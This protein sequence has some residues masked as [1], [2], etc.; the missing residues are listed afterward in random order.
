MNHDPSSQF[1]LAL[2]TGASSGI[3]QS[4]CRLLASN[5]ISL[6]VNGRNQARLEELA[7]DLRSHVPVIEC[8]ADLE[9][10]RGKEK[11]VQMIREY[12]PDLVV[13]S[14]GFGLY[15][16]AL[17]YE[18]SQQLAIVNLNVQV[19]LE[20]TLEAAQAMIAHKKSGVILNISSSTDRLIFPNFSV[21]SASKAFVTH[22]SRSLDYEMRSQ[23]VAVLAACPGMV[24]TAFRKRASDNKLAESYFSMTPE[25]AAKQIWHQIEKRQQVH[26]FDWK[27]RLGIFL[28]HC[29]PKKLLARILSKSVT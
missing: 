20:L 27:T 16:K 13:N 29:L 19:T 4:L 2:V 7:T 1:S 25:F 3:G 5:G 23:G 18:I 21:Y 11:L 9:D 28:S 22:V 15:G 6:I 24:K 14:A 10:Q 8:V 17:S 26:V 12:S